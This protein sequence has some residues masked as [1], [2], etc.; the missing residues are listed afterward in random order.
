MAKYLIKEIISA[1][2]AEAVMKNPH[3]RADVIRP[4]F[5]SV[6]GKL[7]QY[8]VAYS[9]NAVYIIA[10]IP[11]QK[12]MAAILWAFQAGGGPVS[13]TATPIM[14]FTEALEV[15]KKAGELDYK[16]ITR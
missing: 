2:A 15:I 7:E 10:D 6:G 5:E 1:A 4:V 11:N 13:I 16:S 9:E 14:P 12:D 8:Y 3:D